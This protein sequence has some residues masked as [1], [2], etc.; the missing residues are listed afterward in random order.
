MANKAIVKS[1]TVTLALATTAG[2]RNFRVEMPAD[3]KRVA[4]FYVSR[5]SG[6]EYLKITVKDSNGVNVLDPINITHL[7]GTIAQNTG[8][9]V[10]IDDKF[11]RKTPFEA[12]G[13]TMIIQVENFATTAATQ[14]FDFVYECDNEPLL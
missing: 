2:L 12:N 5:N 7:N 11:S 14:E 6:T 4:G 3:Y 1:Y 10:K 13:K 8:A 9:S